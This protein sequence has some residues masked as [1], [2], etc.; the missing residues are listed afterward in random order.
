MI[1]DKLSN[2]KIYAAL[3]PEA[4]KPAADF[5]AAWTPETELGRHVLVPDRVFADVLCYQTQP[6]AERKVEEHARFIDIQAILSGSETICCM[7]TDGLEVLSPMDRELD[8]AFF[9]FAAG[10]E[11]RLSMTEGSFAVFLPGE[12]HLTGW[13][14]DRVTVRKIVVKVAPELLKK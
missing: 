12:G 7:P 1:Y 8:R 2:L 3:A 10:R 5:I 9:K 6:L 11:T 4:W 13:N 14:D